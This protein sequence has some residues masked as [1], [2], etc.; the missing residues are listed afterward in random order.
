[1]SIV[2]NYPRSLRGPAPPVLLSGHPNVQHPAPANSN[3]QPNPSPYTASIGQ[4]FFSRGPATLIRPQSRLRTLILLGVASCLGMAVLGCGSNPPVSGQVTATANPQVASYTVQ[5]DGAANVTIDFG[6]TT[7]YGFRTGTYTIPAPGGALSIL[8]AGMQANTAYHMQAVVDFLNGTTLKDVDHSFTTGSYTLSRLPVVTVTSTPGQVPQPGIEIV[9]TPFTG[10]PI[11]AV[12]LSG[13][14]IWAYDPGNRGTAAWLAPKLLPN[15]DFVALASDSSSS[16]LTT[17]PAPTDPNL[18]REFNLAGDT[19]KQITMNQL[20]TRLAAKG[21]NLQLLLFTH[22]IT[23]LPNGHWLVIANTEK[24]VVLTGAT[25]PTTVLGDVIVDLDTSLQPVWVW[26]E[27]DHLDVNRHPWNFPDWTHTNAVIYSPDDGNLLVSIRHQN[28]IVKIDYQDG[29]GNGD[30]L[31]RLGEGGDFKLVGGTD[32]T[33]WSYAQHGIHF[34]SKYTAGVFPLAVMDNGDDRMYPG[35][36]SATTC[37]TNGAPGCY[38]TVPIYNI[39]ENAM[40]ATIVFHQIMPANLYN[41]WGGNAHVLAN[42]DV[43]YDLCGVGGAVSNSDV[44]EV[45]DQPSPQTVWSLQVTGSNAYRAY[46][47]PSLYPGVQW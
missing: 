30:I 36:T 33:D 35:D 12:D 44:L 14:V 4:R 22:D 39:D 29:A 43:E 42:G 15:G 46:R 10:V 25:T 8:V 40:T 2:C 38:S 37:G 17:V 18:V 45:T 16:V 7:D 28:W 41:S 23:P 19:V 32:P 6:K 13:N 27:F 11:A 5:T 34:A 3:A 26:N 1:M 47:L 31:W 24:S 21:Y 9:N 20:N